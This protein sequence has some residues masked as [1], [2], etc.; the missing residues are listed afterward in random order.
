MNLKQEIKSFIYIDEKGIDSLYCQLPNIITPVKTITTQYTDGKLSSSLG[1]GFLKSLTAKLGSE[2]EAKHKIQEEKQ[3]EITVESKIDAIL[4]NLSNGK[5]ERLFDILEDSYYEG[6]IACKSIFRF[7]SAFD[8]DEERQVF[9]SDINRNPF[10]YKNLSFI[11]A[12][13]PSLQFYSNDIDIFQQSLSSGEYYVDMYFSGSKMVQNVRHL[14]HN[15]KYGSDF[16]LCVL[17]DIMSKGNGYFCLKPFAIWR[18]TNR[19]M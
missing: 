10:K 16:I 4:T 11:F 1:A 18:M 17:G 15:I 9:Q 3:E 6:L 12:S 13:N 19:N 7:M 2:I 5:I 14:T 8:E